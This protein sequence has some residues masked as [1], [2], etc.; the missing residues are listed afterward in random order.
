VKLTN[1]KIRWAVKQVTEKGES[2]AVVAA[3]YSV[4]ARRIERAYN[5]S[6]LGARLL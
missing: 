1:K 3:I 6:F 4:S 5:E 2:T